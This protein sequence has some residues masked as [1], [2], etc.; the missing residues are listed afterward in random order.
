MSEIEHELRMYSDDSEEYAPTAEE[1]DTI[2]AELNTA[3]VETIPVDD[4]FP[5]DDNAIPF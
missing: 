5:F 3:P 1:L 2:Y 4:L